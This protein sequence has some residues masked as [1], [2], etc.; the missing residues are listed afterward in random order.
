M[1]AKAP[2]N[3]R[4][5]HFEMFD[6]TF[7]IAGLAGPHN[8]GEDTGFVFDY[9]KDFGINIIIGL[10]DE[11]NFTDQ[12]KAHGLDY[13]YCRLTDFDT[14]GIPPEVIDQIIQTIEK[15]V[16][17][18]NKVAIH[19]GT[20]NGRTAL[21]ITALKIKQLYE[22]AVTTDPSILDQEVT[23]HSDYKIA[24][25]MMNAEIPT[26]KVVKAAI[27]E[28]RTE[29]KTTD[30][31][32]SA[33]ESVIET[34]FDIMSLLKYQQHLQKKLKATLEEEPEPLASKNIEL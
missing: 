24:G 14:N 30:D 2:K 1:S 13:E 3:F 23:Y 4:T 11:L 19:C 25:T 33:G 10:H 22:A 29:R 16:R 9:L 34:I 31:D 27:E 12:S 7:D 15:N 21:I 26:S 5:N 8:N 20:G 17:S 28:I 32:P 18:S 6:T